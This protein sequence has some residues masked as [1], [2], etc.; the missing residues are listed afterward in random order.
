MWKV[1]DFYFLLKELVKTLVVNEPKNSGVTKFATEAFKTSSKREIQST[2]DATGNLI[3]N[4][5][6]DVVAKFYN[7]EIITRTISHNISS[8]S[9]MH[10]QSESRS[11][12]PRER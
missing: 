7:N 9:I 3:G 12:I 2:D 8:E 1:L 11:E 4:K 10:I 5:I 6:A